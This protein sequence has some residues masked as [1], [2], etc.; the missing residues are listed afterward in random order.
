VVSRTS[1]EEIQE[2]MSQT[3][4]IGEIQNTLGLFTPFILKKVEAIGSQ[5]I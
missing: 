2:L 1:G 5:R 4:P 3:A